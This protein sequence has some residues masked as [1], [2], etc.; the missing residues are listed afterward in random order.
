M[1]QTPSRDENPAVSSLTLLD[2]SFH[3]HMRENLTYKEK[4]TMQEETMQFTSKLSMLHPN[5]EKLCSSLLPHRLSQ[6][7]ASENS[8]RD[9]LIPLNLEIICA[10]MTKTRLFAACGGRDHVADLDLVV[11]DHHAVK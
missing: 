5:A 6:I 4:Y 7:K 2:K 9:V 8:I 10:Q 3:Y 1:L 11:G